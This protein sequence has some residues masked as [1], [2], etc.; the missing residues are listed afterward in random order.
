MLAL[1]TTDPRNGCNVLAIDLSNHP[2]INGSIDEHFGNLPDLERLKLPNTQVAGDIGVLRRNTKLQ[3]LD[4]SNTGVTGDI[5]GLKNARQLA[6]LLLSNTA[7]FGDLSALRSARLE[8]ID[9]SNT[10]VTC[11]QYAAVEAV[12]QSLVG[13]FKF[14]QLGDLR[15]VEGITWMLFCRAV[16]VSSLSAFWFCL[17]HILPFGV[18]WISS[19]FE[20]LDDQILMPNKRVSEI[21]LTKER[22]PTPKN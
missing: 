4:V 2:D 1:L 20:N 5:S 21:S 17:S 10:K 14:W 11:P 7:V 15:K 3:E 16:K 9:V 13:P 22:M 12:L 18:M 8:Q 19:S 6:Q